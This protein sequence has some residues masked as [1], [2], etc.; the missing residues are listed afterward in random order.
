MYSFLTFLELLGG[1]GLFLY[2][3]RIMSDGIQRRSG[4]KFR[5]TL[6]IFT[7]NRFAGVLTGLG[8]TAIIQSSSATTVLLVSIV[9][10]GL[11]GLEQA[12]GVI[13]GANIGT[14][15]TGWI[16]SVLGFKFKITTLALPAIAIAMPM[17][18]SKKEKLREIAGILIGFGILFLGL[19]M[20]KESVP[21]LKNNPEVLEF[22]S[23]FS[24]KGYLSLFLFVAVGTVLTVVVQSSSAAMAITLTMAYKGW[25]DFPTASA[26]VLGENIGTTITAYLASLGMNVNAKRAARAHMLF[27]LVGVAWMFLLFIPFLNGVDA[28]VPGDSADP[29]NIPI[30]LS[31]FH[32]AF[33]IANMGLLIGFVSFIARLARKMV[34]DP[35]EPEELKLTFISAQ[36]AEDVESNLI[37]A[38]AELA[39]MAAMVYDMST[40]VMNALQEDA[41]AIQ[42]TRTKISE[43]EDKTDELQV[44]ISLFLT[45]CMTGSL[46]ED[47]AHRI[48]AM[49]RMAHELE[50]V[51][52]SCKSVI[53]VLEKR[54]L[55]E[56]TFHESGID[57]LIEYQG[58]VMD[59]LKYN[60]DFLSRAISDFS[61]EFARSMED[62]L[63]AQR[64]KLRKVVRRSLS[65]GT[66]VDVRGELAFL[67]IVRHM[68]QVGDACF[69]IS[70]EIIEVSD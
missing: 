56:W 22:L 39:R 25:I 26:I 5:R 38:Q 45:N 55:K 47:Q 28:I 62:N 2:G 19:H 54:A 8:V 57:H 27:N 64:N 32:T 9:N 65:T 48:Q 23:R 33:N 63:N 20:M 29:H 14:T 69:N 21:D 4:S 66:D 51:G 13:M 35:S 17:F 44:S 67:D 53:R 41:E 59:F 50:N 15:L 16:V 7:T 58:H 34:P 49:Y 42:Q 43:Y 68:E 70:E 30:H 52:D 11:I 24:D 60:N 12:I 40:W 3:M 61:L 36:T 1:L 10:A 31:A 6:G 37:S 18:F 46:S